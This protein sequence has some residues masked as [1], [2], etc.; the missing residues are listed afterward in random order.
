MGEFEAELRA[1]QEAFDEGGSSPLITFPDP[2]AAPSKH[3][4]KVF[5]DPSLESEYERQDAV[6]AALESF[7][8]AI[9]L[10]I[11]RPSISTAIRHTLAS[12]LRGR[13][14]KFSIIVPPGVYHNDYLDFQV[15]GM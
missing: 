4:H 5:V 15:I 3:P 2:S 11:T 13:R 10:P 12:A 8:D 14:R 6:Q 1:A 7:E 9:G